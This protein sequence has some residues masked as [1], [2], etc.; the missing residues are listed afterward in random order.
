MKLSDIYL[1]LDLGKLWRG[2]DVFSAVKQLK[3]DIFRHKE[4]RRTL[5][6]EVTGKSYFLKYHQG[7]GWLEI[8]KNLL[9]FRKPIISAKNEWEA[10]KFLEKHDIDTMTV[11]GYG[12][13][14]FNP[15]KIE[16]FVITDDLSDTVSL[17]QLGQYWTEKPP[18]FNT[19]KA[20]IERL[21]LTSKTMHE[22]GMNHR[23]YYLC[24]FLLDKGFVEH[25]TFTA[26]TKLFLIDLHRAIIRQTGK[27][28]QRWLVKDIGALYFSA[29]D[30]SLTSRDLIRF[31]KTY[32]GLNLHDI[33]SKQ[34]G[35]WNK[36]RFRAD[37]MRSANNAAINQEL[38][39]IRSFLQ[40]QKNLTV[41]FTI[42][43][44]EESFECQKVLRL[45]PGKRLVVEAK[46]KR[47]HA[48]VKFFASA[49]KGQRELE[50]EYQGYQLAKQAGVLVPERLFSG[51]NQ[52][53]CLMVA[54][55]F[56][57]NGETLLQLDDSRRN[58]QLGALFNCISKLHSYG[59]YQNDIHL[60][61][62][63]LADSKLYLIDL[64]SIK[65]QRPGQGLNEISSLNNIARLIAQFT[66]DER[67]LLHPH[68]KQYYRERGSGYNNRARARLAQLTNKAWQKRKNNYL[69]KCFR[70]CTDTIYQNN[71]SR[72]WAF[73]SDFL[74]GEVE[75]FILDIEK[76]V[77]EGELLKEGKSAT[78]VRAE[79]AGRQLVIKRYNLKSKWHFMR[80]CFRASRAAASWKNANLLKLLGISTAN[81][82]GF[83][84]NR[85]V[86]L[87]H[88]AYYICEYTPAV[89][90]SS[91]YQQRVPTD[92][93]LK[94]FQHIFS[95]LR[96]AKVSHGDLK[97]SN[98]L[99]GDSGKITLI[100]LDSMKQHRYEFAF[101]KA[102]YKDQVR[103]L[104]NWRDV[105]IKKILE[106]IIF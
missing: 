43:A 27:V 53:G 26:D 66:F 2:E 82:I 100:D 106:S 93:E 28:E 102:F 76:I 13:R 59:I 34:G 1:R 101:E 49:K 64:G 50:R 60:D 14:G 52:Q 79:V 32:S 87:R 71:A 18:T 73:N 40:G 48:T 55:Q 11:A 70:N 105:K 23:D 8:V 75:S 42:Q 36:V 86:G 6:F 51:Y 29:M 92:S 37:K 91:I 39:P 96:Q 98:F 85:I 68:I 19:K 17:E 44:L 9:Q 67:G 15:A 84:E 30:V 77:A 81:P 103:F 20:L 12:K 78:I 61:N 45:L 10:I 38:N 63:L 54:Y 47:H 57:N 3:G 46:S 69:K 94:Q 74:S 21:A 83:I 25:N 31:A 99:I 72:Q 97:A 56:C 104:A 65:K 16:S 33:I 58:E 95:C 35:F 41:P 4:G 80:R 7:V 24:H 88:T 62:F 90:L 5:R 22:N 89:E